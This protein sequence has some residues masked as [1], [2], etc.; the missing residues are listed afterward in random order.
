MPRLFK[1]AA[2]FSTSRPSTWLVPSQHSNATFCTFLPFFWK[3][4]CLQ[5]RLA[6][7]QFARSFPPRNL[8]PGKRRRPCPLRSCLSL[9]LHLW[10]CG[11]RHIRF[12]GVKIVE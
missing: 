9:F 6:N 11:T 5:N 3:R 7:L 8:Q 4:E 1:R 2:N 12:E 10:S